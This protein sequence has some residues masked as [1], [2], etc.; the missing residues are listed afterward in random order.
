MQPK[1]Y[2]IRCAVLPVCR[3]YGLRAVAYVSLN[4]AGAELAYNMTYVA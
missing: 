1:G 4:T 3:V 2:T